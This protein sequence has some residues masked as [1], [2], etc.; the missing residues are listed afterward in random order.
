VLPRP[1]TLADLDRV[2]D[3]DGTIESSEYLH[4]ER[5][6]EG[7][8]AEW[9]LDVR[10][11]RTRLI[12]SNA[13]DD[14]Q[15]FALKQIIGGADE[16]IALVVEHDDAPVALAAAQLRAERGALQVFD[17]R[18]DFD[19]RRE[20]IATVL[21]YQIIQQAR[22]RGLRAVSAQTRTNNLPAARMFQKLA[23]ELAGL[24]TH[25]HS[26]HDLVKESATL[27]WYAAL[28]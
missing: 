13:L 8:S 20:G 27:F 28:D 19:V 10:P 5:S 1:A 2:L 16:G 6:G 21:V 7:L 17:V 26:N 4:L 12:Q 9:K 15:R 11:L 14:A 22:Q 24:D 3:I 25:R 23:F 18:V